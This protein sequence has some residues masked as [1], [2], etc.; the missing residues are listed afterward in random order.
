[1]HRVIHIIHKKNRKIKAKKT[2]KI[3]HMFC[4]TMIKFEGFVK[5][6]YKLLDSFRKI[7][8]I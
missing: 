1:M 5:K 4:E 8:D 6:V 2:A 3:K 7:S